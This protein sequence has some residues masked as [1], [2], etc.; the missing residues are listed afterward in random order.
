MT[1]DDV[2]EA[3][4][5]LLVSGGCAHCASAQTSELTDDGSRRLRVYHSPGCPVLTALR[6]VER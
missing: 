6:M 1:L 4:E 2:F 5:D 3:V